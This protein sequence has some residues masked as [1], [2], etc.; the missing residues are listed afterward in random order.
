MDFRKKYSFTTNELPMGCSQP[1]FSGHIL[2]FGRIKDGAFL[3]A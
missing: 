1:L 2:P 3:V